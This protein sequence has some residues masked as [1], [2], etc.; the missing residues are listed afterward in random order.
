MDAISILALN[1]TSR[2]EANETTIQTAVSTKG[3]VTALFNVFPDFLSYTDG[4]Y[5]ST[6]CND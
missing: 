3:P 1:G 6:K 4:I 5:T 2:I